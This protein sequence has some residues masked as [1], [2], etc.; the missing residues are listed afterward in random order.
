MNNISSFKHAFLYI[1][2]DYSRVFLWS[3]VQGCNDYINA[4]Y[5]PVST[6]VQCFYLRRSNWLFKTCNKQVKRKEWYFNNHLY[7]LRLVA[8]WYF[9]CM[10]YVFFSSII[11]TVR[12]DILCSFFLQIIEWMIFPELQTTVCLYYYGDATGSYHNRFLQ[13]SATRRMSHHCNVK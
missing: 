11:K 6:S 3:S 12:I 5:V 4:I 7:C 1:L 2:D 9:V 13:T 8:Q 10:P